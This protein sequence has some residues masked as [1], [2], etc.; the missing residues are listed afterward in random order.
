MPGA[1][2][3]DVRLLRGPLLR[4][5]PAAVRLGGRSSQS[6]CSSDASTR[7]ASASSRA[8]GRIDLD[9]DTDAR[10]VVDDR[11]HR[12]PTRECERLN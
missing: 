12:V 5:T 7:A 1:D 4:G 3:L 9:V 10:A 11:D 2:R 6:A 8:R